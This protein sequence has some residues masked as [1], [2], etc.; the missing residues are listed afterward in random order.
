MVTMLNFV[1][2]VVC[3]K[4]KLYRIHSKLK[5]TTVLT[6]RRIKKLYSSK[7]DFM[8]SGRNSTY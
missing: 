5:L 1:V 2:I 7:V 3:D 8:G 6:D 4:F